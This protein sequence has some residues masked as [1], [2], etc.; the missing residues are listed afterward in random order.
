[1]T[2]SVV[3]SAATDVLAVPV[4]ALLAL[5]EGGYAVEL[6]TGAGRSDLV[7]VELGAFADG[8]VEVTGDI[9]EGDEVEVPE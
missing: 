8:W 6:V 3:T 7:A 9:A 1:M 4:D 2:V 5:A